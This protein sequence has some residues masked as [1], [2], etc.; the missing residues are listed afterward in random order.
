M[1]SLL[2]LAFG[3]VFGAAQAQGVAELE[4]YFRSVRSLSGS[5]EQTTLDEQEKPIER[6]SGSVLIQRPDRFRWHY[7]QPFEQLIVAD[8]KRLWVYDVDLMQATVRP[9]G[10]VL[11]V[12]PA[13]LLSGDYAS[14]KRSFDIAAESDGWLR[15]TPREGDW[16]FQAVRLRMA[17]GVPAVIEV[18][19]GLGQITRLELFDLKRNPR[20][21]PAQF[22]FTP[23]KGVDVVDPSGEAEAR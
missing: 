8:G 21:D 14:L 6:S 16:D 19:T 5:F 12:G 23:P 18:D 9:L 13:L 17:D 15:L 4:E 3:L 1:K 7:D 11:G 10:D 22:R 20:I 2:V